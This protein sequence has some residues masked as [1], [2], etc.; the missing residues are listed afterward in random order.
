MTILQWILISLGI[1]AGVA[2]LFVGAYCI[3]YVL[4]TFASANPNTV[5]NTFHRK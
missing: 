4:G 5:S 2:F 3:A 1:V